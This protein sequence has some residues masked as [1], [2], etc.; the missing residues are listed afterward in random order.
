MTNHLFL[1]S[2]PPFDKTE[3]AREERAQAA[4]AKKKPKPGVVAKSSVVLE[5]KPWDDE[6]DL[7]KLEEAVRSVEMQGLLWGKS[8]L[9]PVAFG[10]KKL[11]IVCVVE[12]DHVSIEELSEKIEAFEDYVQSVDVV[13]FNK[14]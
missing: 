6:T 8:E 13:A 10:V 1:S 3:K 2:S 11:Q 4:Q 5:I 12:D 7:A 14:I 9:K